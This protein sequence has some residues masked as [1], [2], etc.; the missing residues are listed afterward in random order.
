MENKE[1]TFGLR[2]SW[3]ETLL[4]HPTFSPLLPSPLSIV[5]S[6]W[7]CLYSLRSQQPSREGGEPL[8]ILKHPSLPLILLLTLQAPR[9]PLGDLQFGSSLDSLGGPDLTKAAWLAVS[10]PE[11]K[12]GSLSIVLR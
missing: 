3:E 12:V 10:A 6:S 5:G 1:K 4:P 9:C 8:R 7:T 2:V 11:R